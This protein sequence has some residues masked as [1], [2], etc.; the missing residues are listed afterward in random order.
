[1]DTHLTL[2]FLAAYVHQ[3]K[4]YLEAWRAKGLSWNWGAALFGVAWFAYRKMY[5]WATFI[6]LVNLFVG[7]ALG[8]MVLDEASFN[9][10]YLLFALFQRV[11]LGLVCN[12]LYYVSAVRK[13]KKAYSKNAMLDLEDTRKL[14]GVSVRGVVVVVFVNIGFSLLDVLLTS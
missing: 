12:F 2:N 10:V 7:F 11:L 6:Y 5:G 3:H 9:E 8:A 4:Y 1:M 13:I 14:G